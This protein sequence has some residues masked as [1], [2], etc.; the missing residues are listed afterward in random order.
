MHT[1]FSGVLMRLRLLAVVAALMLPS[2]AAHADTLQIF[3]IS[4]AFEHGVG[5]GGQVV[6]DT[7][8]N[9]FTSFGGAAGG[10]ATGN[11]G[12]FS[13]SQGVSNGDYF[14]DSATTGPYT[15]SI[16]LPVTSLV[17]YNGSA[18][19]TESL[20]SGC[21]ASSYLDF[22]AISGRL[23]PIAST[24]VTPEPSSIALLGTGMLG[25]AG[26]IRKRFV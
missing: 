15:L 22:P 4:I 14:L 8:T 10:L 26:V 2:L 13:A 20:G 16:I 21:F 9:L 5:F 25:V 23:T 7:T 18:V 19:C 6:L 3:E 24:T 11:G 1:R 17:D 12:F